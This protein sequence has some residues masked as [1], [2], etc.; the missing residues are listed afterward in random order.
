MRIACIGTQCIGKSTYVKDFLNKWT[1]YNTPK[2]SYRDIIKEKKLTVNESGTEESQK[3][4]L[5]A[6]VDQ[7]LS[8]DKDDFVIFDRS[9]LDNL[10]YTSWLY[11]KNKVSEKFLDE[12]KDIVSNSLKLYDILLFFPITKFSQIQLEQDGLRS[13]D[14]VYREEIDT[15]FKIFQDSYLKGDRKIFPE[16]DC[17]AIIEIYGT[18]EQR[19]KMTELY[20]N[21]NGKPYGEEDSLISSLYLPDE[22]QPKIKSI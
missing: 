1:M 6:L 17:P 11:L 14:P 10:A 5:D 22:S 21:E 16:Y 20:L 7:L 9:V 4:I 2:K 8:T 3:I 13:V 15:I 18:P 19:I 12:T